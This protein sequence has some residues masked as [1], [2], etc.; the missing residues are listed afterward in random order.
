MYVNPNK[1]NSVNGNT[2]SNANN[3]SI[4]ISKLFDQIQQLNEDLARIRD[5]KESLQSSDDQGGSESS[6]VAASNVAASNNVTSNA[7]KFW[8]ALEN[9]IR[10]RVGNILYTIE[11]NTNNSYS[12]SNMTDT[13]VSSNS[14]NSNGMGGGI[15][16]GAGESILNSLGSALTSFG[17]KISNGISS[18]GGAVGD[19]AKSVGDWFLT[20]IQGPNNPTEDASIQNG[21]CGPA[22]LAMILRKKGLMEGGAAN[23]ESQ[24]EQARSMMT[25]ID[26]EKITPAEE[27]KWTNGADIAAGAQKAGLGAMAY[28]GKNMDDVK[29]AI[30]EGKEV[31]V[32]I[33]PPGTPTGHFVLVTGMQGDNLVTADPFRGQNTIVT[34]DEFTTKGGYMTVIG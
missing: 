20:Q 30:S 32:L 16:G 26:P 7:L 2:A 18:I 15:S 11:Q 21:N 22:V 3:S 4:N 23:A 6:N 5:H 29:Q 25:G 13:A 27:M 8:E 28:S 31:V 12:A 24:I 33:D 17:E 14:D 9:H 1:N 19:A 34:S 10:S